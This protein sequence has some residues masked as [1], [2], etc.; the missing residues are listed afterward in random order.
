MTGGLG[1][2]SE[3]A[4]R[5]LVWYPSRKS[6][7]SSPMGFRANSHPGEGPL[8]VM[9]GTKSRM[10]VGRKCGKDRDVYL[11]D[12]HIAV[13]RTPQQVPVPRLEVQTPIRKR[14]WHYREGKERRH[15]VT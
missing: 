15:D 2:E 13:W 7:P 11:T 1:E 12:R 14:D 10:P 6:R 8:Y 4:L 5:G 3:G 9:E